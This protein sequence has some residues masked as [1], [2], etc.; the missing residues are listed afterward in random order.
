MEDSW[1]PIKKYIK[2]GPPL[3]GPSDT[4]GVGPA[5]FWVVSK[6]TKYPLQATQLAMSLMSVKEQLFFSK[7]TDGDVG[8]V[9]KAA[10]KDPAFYSH[11]KGIERTYAILQAKSSSHGRVIPALPLPDTLQNDIGEILQTQL[12]NVLI[13]NESVPKALKAAQ[14]QAQAALNKYWASVKK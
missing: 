14:T 13:S 9:S 1:G 4:F 3:Y 12:N 11:L 6:E 7:L 8:P 2:I 10:I 5:F